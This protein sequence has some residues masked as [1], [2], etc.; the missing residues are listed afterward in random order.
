MAELLSA[1]CSERMLS[2]RSNTVP[3]HLVGD[4]KA[5]EFS[6]VLELL[7][8][9]PTA[10]AKWPSQKRSTALKW[11]PRTG[12]RQKL[13]GNRPGC[14]SVAG[15]TGSPLA[16]EHATLAYEPEAENSRTFPVWLLQDV[17]ATATSEGPRQVSPRESCCWCDMGLEGGGQEGDGGLEAIRRSDIPPRALKHEGAPPEAKTA[18]HRR[19]LGEKYGIE[20]P[21]S[22]VEVIGRPRRL[23]VGSRTWRSC[24][25][26]QRVCPNDFRPQ[27]QERAL[28]RHIIG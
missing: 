16:S 27:A 20:G 11:I 1:K 6:R 17:Q 26:S 10:Q 22:S 23:A 8:S 28:L 25:H 12:T 5:K 24:S 14:I 7:D 18:Y 19:D 9:V 3:G 21:E 13:Q 15:M 2:E 4:V